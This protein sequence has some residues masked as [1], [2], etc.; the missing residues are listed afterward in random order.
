M[1]TG[2]VSTIVLAQI[3]AMETTQGRVVTPARI[4]SITATT[5]AGV[6]RLEPDAGQRQPPDPGIEWLVQAE[7]TFTNERTP[8]GAAAMVA[9][10]GFFVIA[11]GDGSIIGFGFP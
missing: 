2:E 11:D 1:T 9:S 5:S 10:S 8:P 6:A 3:H 7:G 4:V